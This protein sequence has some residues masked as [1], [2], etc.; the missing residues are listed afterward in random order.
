VVASDSG[1]ASTARDVRM[2]RICSPSGSPSSEDFQHRVETEN[3]GMHPEA[4]DHSFRNVRQDAVYVALGK[5]ADMDL[6]IRQRRTLYAILQSKSRIGKSGRVHD[7]PIEAL[8]CCPI[9]AVDRFAFDI[10]VE[11]LQLV[12]VSSSDGVV[13][14]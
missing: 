7:Q 13:E 1:E 8:L 5:A 12:A 10:G 4:G 9:D 11:D 14:P 6:D 3:I 2:F